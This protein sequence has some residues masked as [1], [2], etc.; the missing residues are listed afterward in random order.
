MSY[1]ERVIGKKGVRNDC[2]RTKI[3]FVIS[4]L[5]FTDIKDR[6]KT[7]TPTNTIHSPSVIL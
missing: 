4:W 2:F 6:I 7:S 3:R 1:T 5:Y